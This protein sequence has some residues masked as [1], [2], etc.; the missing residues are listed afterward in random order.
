MIEVWLDWPDP[1]LM[2]NRARGL[3]WRTKG[4]VARVARRSA[5]V[6]ALQAGCHVFSTHSGELSVL[7]E[8]SAPDKRR[9]DKDNLI[10]AFKPQQDG[11]ADACGVDDSRFD[12]HHVLAEPGR[13]DV[14]VRIEAK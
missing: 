10:A 3:H 9:R 7:V 8:F 2:P 13:G 6:L 14:R 11:I 5:W 4:R 12:V 1:R